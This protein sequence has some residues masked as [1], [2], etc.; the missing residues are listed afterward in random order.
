MFEINEP[1]ASIG[2]ATLDQLGLCRERVNLNGSALVLG[3]PYGMSGTRIVG[4][5]LRELERID[6]RLGIAAACIGGEWELL[7]CSSAETA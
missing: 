5:L 4:A 3:H 2:L 7:H 6:G 1:F